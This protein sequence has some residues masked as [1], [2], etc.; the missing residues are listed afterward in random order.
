[1]CILLRGWKGDRHGNKIVLILVYYNKGFCRGSPPLLALIFSM[2]IF[3]N[4]IESNNSYSGFKLRKV[5]VFFY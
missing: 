4:L 1:M 2:V 5:S 3:I